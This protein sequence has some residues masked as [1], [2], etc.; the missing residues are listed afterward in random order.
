MR[1]L[2]ETEHAC[3]LRNSRGDK[4][5]G[6]NVTTKTGRKRMKADE[7]GESNRRTEHFKSTPATLARLI[8]HANSYQL[9]HQVDSRRFAGR[10]KGIARDG[11]SGRNVAV[12]TGLPRTCSTQGM[13]EAGTRSLRDVT[14]PL[15][16]RSAHS[17]RSD[18]R[19]K[20]TRPRLSIHR[21]QRVP[22]IDQKSI[23]NAAASCHTPV[24]PRA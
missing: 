22:L 3:A 23:R 1:A 21:G 14:G 24:R 16:A 10:T 17:E 19:K 13:R 12:E 4:G 5:A 18:W 7:T 9:Q 6:H 11:G 8:L 20:C 15:K 2:H